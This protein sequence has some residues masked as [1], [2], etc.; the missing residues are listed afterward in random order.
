MQN[1]QTFLR[2][3]KTF[4]QKKTLSLN[5]ILNFSKEKEKQMKS[6]LRANFTILTRK[7]KNKTKSLQTS[8]HIIKDLL[9]LLA[10]SFLDESRCARLYCQDL[11]LIFFHTELALG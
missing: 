3:G 11:G 1:L 5:F 8:G 4:S 2:D 7:Y 10:R 6:I 9:T